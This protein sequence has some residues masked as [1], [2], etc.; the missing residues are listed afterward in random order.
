[1]V[2]LSGNR[3]PGSGSAGKAHLLSTTSGV[4]GT[5]PKPSF[6]RRGEPQAR[7]VKPGKQLSM[8][9]RNIRRRADRAK[10]KAAKNAVKHAALSAPIALSTDALHPAKSQGEDLKSKPRVYPEMKPR[11]DYD[12]GGVFKRNTYNITITGTAGETIPVQI[13][14]CDIDEARYRAEKVWDALIDAMS[15]S[16]IAWMDIFQIEDA[17]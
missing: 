11:G 16:V 10:N 17:D 3:V 15:E 13:C 14:A 6:A 8:S 5:G 12:W 9:K 7:P 2:K 1:M 4:G